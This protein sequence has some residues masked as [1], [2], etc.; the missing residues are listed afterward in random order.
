MK[1]KIV[2]A[3]V[4]TL[5]VLLVYLLSS[6]IV[7]YTRNPIPLFPKE[8]VFYCMN[9]AEASLAFG[10]VQDVT[11]SV[12]DT[13]DAC[14]AYVRPVLGYEANVECFFTDSSHL[15]RISITWS[16]ETTEEASSV[17]EEALSL[18][19]KEYGANDDFFENEETVSDNGKR[20]LSI[21]VNYGA[22]GV[23]YFVSVEGSTVSVWG[24][25][26]V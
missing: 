6:R 12:C 10:A 25:Y 4:I 18:I 16:L 23:S 9:P 21:G 19:R 13:P 24:Y 3:S 2:I 8:Y 15:H 7:T 22:T 17:Y 14:Y 20:S 11:P 5:A 26:T 1:K